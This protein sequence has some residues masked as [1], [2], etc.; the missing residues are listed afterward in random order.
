[1]QEFQR[2]DISKLFESLLQLEPS[3]IDTYLEAGHIEWAVM[4]NREK[5]LEHIKMGIEI[6]SAKTKELQQLLDTI[7]NND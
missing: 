1:M 6:T 2:T 4:N 7:K 5:A 3:N